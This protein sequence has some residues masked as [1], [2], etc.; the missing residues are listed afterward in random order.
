VPTGD[1]RSGRT[2]CSSDVPARVAPPVFDASELQ[3]NTARGRV[4]ASAA[5]TNG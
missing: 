3:V 5:C 1:A 4:T 2:T